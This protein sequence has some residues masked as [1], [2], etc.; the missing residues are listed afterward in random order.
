MP[1]HSTDG[2]VYGQVIDGTDLPVPG[3]QV[4]IRAY[5]DTCP[6]AASPFFDQPAA[7]WPDGR[8]RYRLR[9]PDF[10]DI[11][12]CLDVTASAVR[13]GASLVGASTGQFL[14]LRSQLSG[15]LDSTFVLGRIE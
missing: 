7:A 10:G 2:V 13:D 11:L 9:A 15:G 3:A 8:Y 4:R 1:L 14:T 5:Q 6:S 12:L